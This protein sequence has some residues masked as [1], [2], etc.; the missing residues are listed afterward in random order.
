MAK[1]AIFI[2]DY[3]ANGDTNLKIKSVQMIP[4]KLK[5]EFK[6]IDWWFW[7][8]TLIFILAALTGW[9]PSYIIVIIISAL[10]VIY[11]WAKLKSLTAFDTQVRIVYFTI[12][13]FGL[14]NAIRFPLFF[15]LFFGTFMVVF[16]NRCG[17][18]LG[19][20]YMP[21]NRQNLV[22]IDDMIK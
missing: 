9:A 18:A 20:K 14:I 15:L 11:F 19:L 4:M 5:L 22:K 10:Q 3:I 7:V 17:I 2:L 1:L 16:F 13:L 6:K 21:W 8:I 12:T